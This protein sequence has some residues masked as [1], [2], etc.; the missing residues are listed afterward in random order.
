MGKMKEKHI[1]YLNGDLDKEEYE[2][3]KIDKKIKE[4]N[5]WMK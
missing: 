5:E 1:E 4:V 2:K 3:L